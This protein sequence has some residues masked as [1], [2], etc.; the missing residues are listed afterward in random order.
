MNNKLLLTG[1]LMFACSVASADNTQIKLGEFSTGSLKGWESKAFSGQTQYQIKQQGN[2]KSLSAV[3]TGSASGLGVKKRIDLTKTPF[4][5]WS[6]RVDKALPPLK[7]AT[8]AGDDYAARLYVIID[9]GLF[10]WKTRALNYVWSSN[11]S[12]GTKWNNA[13]A[14]RNARMLAVRDSRDG[15]GQWLKEKQSVAEDFKNLY[16]FVPRYIDGVALMTDT[17]NSGGTAAASYGDIFFSA[18]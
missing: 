8:K 16:G 1:A 9:G 18:K 2:R 12:K 4:L 10:I 5:N 14:P 6:W 13:F 7:E 3:A 17:D 15:P 11:P